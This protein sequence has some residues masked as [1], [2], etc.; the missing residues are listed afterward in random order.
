MTAKTAIPD[1][2]SA[3]SD[4][5]AALAAAFPSGLGQDIIHL[6]T[7]HRSQDAIL[8]N[9][10]EKGLAAHSDTGRYRLV[11]D[12]KDRFDPA[13]I[14]TMRHRLVKWA[15]RAVKEASSSG[16]SDLITGRLEEIDAAIRSAIV[17]SLEK[18][19]L[20]LAVHMLPA[21]YAEGR[22]DLVERMARDLL[23]VAR[24]QETR[25]YEVLLLGGLGDA[26]LSQGKRSEAAIS[27][28]EAVE[29]AR[30]SR[31]LGSE[32]K[33]LGR[34]AATLL[35]LGKPEEAIK[36]A[37]RAIRL[38]RDTNLPA[39]ASACSEAAARACDVLGR[40]EEAKGYRLQSKLLGSRE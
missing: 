40:I 7:D 12:L 13:V 31:D 28:I 6:F 3:E 22:W 14:A 35:D 2:S 18:N 24:I 20:D 39:D 21:A 32:C 38:C 1:L 30:E 36:A 34:L 27:F 23:P 16:R 10:E 37:D 11:E 25:R 29:G 4:I 5:A 9:L 19:A 17:E 8:K 26:L 33:W 15:S